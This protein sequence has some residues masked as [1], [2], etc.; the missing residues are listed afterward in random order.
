MR[1]NPRQKAVQAAA[2][3]HLEAGRALGARIDR[4]PDATREIASFALANDL[5]RL[6]LPADRGGAPAD[7]P[8]AGLAHRG[9][10]YEAL[11]FIDP[12][13]AF[14]APG[15]GM[16]GIVVA[17][18]GSRDQE[19]AFF[20]RFEAGPA[21]SFFALT[22]PAYGSDAGS[23][24]LAARPV[25][26]GWRLSGEKYLVG[27]GVHAD[28]GVVFA[29]FDDG[30]L[31]IRPVLLDPAHAVGFS[32]RRLAVAGCRAANVSHLMFADV[33]VPREAVLGE[34]LRPT[35]RFRRGASATFDALR[36]CVALVAL[37]LARGT[38]TRALDEGL[39]DAAHRDFVEGCRLAIAG[40]SNH[41]LDLCAAADAGRRLSRD[42][43]LAKSLAYR[44]AAN[45]I[46]G[47]VRRA[48]PGAALSAPWLAKASRDVGAFE[49]AEG[50]SAIHRLG[51]ADAFLGGGHETRH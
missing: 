44:T 40:L 46:A 25:A 39:L 37:G 21:W 8:E 13:L 43:G 7:A 15:P 41:C 51:A 5:N 23:I 34:H 47:I 2:L 22:E 20:S 26:G 42:A 32:A 16:A 48:P 36:P 45:V 9:A 38:L 30:P 27:H 24:G 1:L 3:A 10:L 17:N 29:R 11:G 14:G 6:G 4:D 19:R 33:F 49:Y 12:N 28:I 31:G 50:V 18:L 35:E